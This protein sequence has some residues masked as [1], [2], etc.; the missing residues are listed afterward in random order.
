MIVELINTLMAS[1]MALMYAY[2]N[3]SSRDVIKTRLQF[4]E[5]LDKEM[6]NVTINLIRLRE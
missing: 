5:E 6:E 2:L 1:T 3:R 4:R